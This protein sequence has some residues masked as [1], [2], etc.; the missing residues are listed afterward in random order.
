M[1]EK[2]YLKFLCARSMK[3]SFSLYI[4]NLY[5]Y[6]Y[7]IDVTVQ[8][9]KHITVRTKNLIRNRNFGLVETV[10]KP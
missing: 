6:I 5:I 10:N 2:N 9:V 4:I 8:K 3:K 1:L 7:T